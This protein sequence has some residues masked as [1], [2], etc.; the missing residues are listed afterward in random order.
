MSCPAFGGLMTCLSGY[1]AW[2]TTSSATCLQAKAEETL[3]NTAPQLMGLI[4]SM[5]HILSDLCAVWR[6]L[7][8]GMIGI[9]IGIAAFYLAAPALANEGTA[10]I[11][12]D[13]DFDFSKEPTIELPDQT[14]F[15]D[16]LGYRI[17]E[18]LGSPGHM[19][20]DGAAL[21]TQEP[22]VLT[23]SH[24]CATAKVR[25]YVKPLAPKTSLTVA[26]RYIFSI[27]DVLNP[28]PHPSVEYG[29]LVDNVT[30]HAT[31]ETDLN[32]PVRAPILDDARSSA[33]CL[34]AAQQ[35]AE[36][37][38]GTVGE[39]TSGVVP[40]LGTVSSEMSVGCGILGGL[41]L[42]I[43]IAFQKAKL[44]TA[45]RILASKA[46]ELLTGAP[47]QLLDENVLRCVNTALSDSNELADVDFGGGVRVECQ[48]FERDGGGGSITLLRR[49]GK[50]TKLV[51]LR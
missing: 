43:Y 35:I 25:L 16:S 13:D 21:I 10:K 12:A 3:R 15:F 19:M 50:Q 20:Q 8:R 14:V 36:A 24:S 2:I 1:H 38:K 17:G 22:L 41:P 9:A 29:N 51:G 23:K 37:V 44:S 11:C 7:M 4:D 42:D 49:F 27:D 32:D 31:L 28:S 46:G 34:S 26:D 33:E 30:L 45:T 18:K 6:R 47:A 48:A 5:N 40:I 39:Q